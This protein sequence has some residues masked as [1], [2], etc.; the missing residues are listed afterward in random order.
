[1]PLLRLIA[2][3]L[4]AAGLAGASPTVVHRGQLTHIA[5]T[6]ATSNGC[7]AHVEYAD[8]TGVDLGIKYPV[9]HRVAWT[10]RV[11]AKA[12]LG[13]AQW[14]VRCV[15]YQYTG[16]WL[17]VPAGVT[18]GSK[19]PQLIVS[20]EGFS[21]RPDSFGTGSTVSYG[22]LIRNPS[23]RK[24]AHDVTATISFVDANGNAIGRK[25]VTVARIAAGETFAL[26]GSTE[27]SG[28]LDAKKLNATLRAGS[29]TPAAG[30]PRPRVVNAK[31]VAS[32]ADPGWVGEV[33]GEIVNDTSPQTLTRAVV[34]IVVVDASGRIVG[35]GSGLLS[36][37]L[38]SGA[39]GPFAAR[40][41]FAAIA[42]GDAVRPVVSVVP[43]YR[44]S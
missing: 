9:E 22:L 44:S 12:P 43:T 18:V 23:L 42:V 40:L 19:P 8:A 26:G 17:I 31:I 16:T 41:G 11:P 15:I 1:V 6:V 27:L 3:M 10:Y 24:D 32:D 33:D 39:R 37:P 7:L 20:K 29:Y 35:G 30:R 21:Q 4:L 2:P 28:Q 14:S 34:S 36:S 13:V 25:K 38:A 5:V